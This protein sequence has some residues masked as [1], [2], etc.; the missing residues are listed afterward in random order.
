MENELLQ[1][2]VVA[3]ITNHGS[4]LAVD[5]LYK[6]TVESGDPDGYYSLGIG[7][8]EI[9]PEEESLPYLTELATKRDP[10][11]HLAVKSLLNYGTD[12]LKTVIEI[13]ENSDDPE[14][15]RQMLEDAVDH[16]NYEEET[17]GYLKQIMSNTEKPVVTEFA[18]EILEDF[19]LEDDYD[20][21][22]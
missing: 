16:V 3:A 19:E 8:G 17:E 4:R 21:D 18:K 13:L 14:F 15:D 9:I 7:L 1:E 11:S 22:Y 5:V 10:Y 12:G 20:E 2:S 6:H